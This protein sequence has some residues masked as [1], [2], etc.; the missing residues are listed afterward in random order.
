MTK[1]NLP[2]LVSQDTEVA[3][4]KTKNLFALTDRLLA[5]KT[6]LAVAVAEALPALNQPVTLYLALGHTDWVLSVAFSP[7]GKSVI[8]GSRVINSCK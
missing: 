3:L 4:A 8:S 5:K 1:P 2:S 7:D 6:A